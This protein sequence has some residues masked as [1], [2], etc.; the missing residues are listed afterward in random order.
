[1]SRRKSPTTSDYPARHHV[2]P[3]TSTILGLINSLQEITTTPTTHDCQDEARRAHACRSPTK[4]TPQRVERRVLTS[5]KP[6]PKQYPPRR[7]AFKSS[8]KDHSLEAAIKEN[9]HRRTLPKQSLR[10]R[11][12][13]LHP[14]RMDTEASLLNTEAMLH[15]PRLHLQ[16]PSIRRHP[17][18]DKTN[19]YRRQQ[20][21]T[22]PTMV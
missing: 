14:N 22:R 13:C 10:A 18:H 17:M 12:R 1:L 21:S 5:H 11:P 8:F 4:R 2:D 3:F 9:R 19:T 6:T 15:V 20:E 7:P 16:T